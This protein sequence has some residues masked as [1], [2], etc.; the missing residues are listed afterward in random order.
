MLGRV[1]AFTCVL[2]LGFRLLGI[3]AGGIIGQT[4]G[5]RPALC[6]GASSMLAAA[7]FLLANASAS[8]KGLIASPVSEGRNVR[9]SSS[10][11]RSGS[12]FS[13]I[14]ADPQSALHS[15]AGSGPRLSAKAS[16]SARAPLSNAGRP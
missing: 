4:V 3:V 7:V 5:L 9:V 8:R 16:S 6:I 15:V 13:S 1:N 12:R 11:Q 14:N 10:R 2:D